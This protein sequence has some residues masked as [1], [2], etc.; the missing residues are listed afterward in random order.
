MGLILLNNKISFH[1]SYGQW[2]KINKPLICYQNQSTVFCVRCGTARGIITHWFRSE[3]HRDMAA[4]ARALVQGS[5]NAINYQREFSFRCLFKVIWNCCCFGICKRF[6][7]WINLMSAIL[8]I[9]NRSTNLSWSTKIEKIAPYF[10]DELIP[11]IWEIL[12]IVTNWLIMR[13][14]SLFLSVNF[15]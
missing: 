11:G 6:F 1:T 4:W 14:F 13:I 7:L 15:K 10:I 12:S 8:K 9:R 5:H 2:Y 3:T